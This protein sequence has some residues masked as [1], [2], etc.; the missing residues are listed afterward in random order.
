MIVVTNGLAMSLNETAI[1]FNEHCMQLIRKRNHL[2]CQEAESSALTQPQ[3]SQFV[4][5]WKRFALGCAIFGLACSA[6]A[7]QKNS[8][9]E[10]EKRGGGSYQRHLALMERVAENAGPIDLLFV[11]DSITQAW[12]NSGKNV[13]QRYYASNGRKSVNI[14]ISGDRT[15]HVLWRLNEGAVE[16]LEPKVAVVMIGTN[17]SGSDRNSAS[18]MVEGVR[19]VVTRLH[20]LLPETKILLL[21]IFPRGEE[22]NEIRGKILQ[23]NQAVQKMED[24]MEGTVFFLDIGHRF[25]QSDGRISTDIMPDFLHLTEAGYEI[26]AQSIEPTLASLLSGSDASSVEAKSTSAPFVAEAPEKDPFD[27]AGDWRWLIRGP[28]NQLVEFLMHLETSTEDSSVTGYFLMSNDQGER[29]LE[30]L[31]GSRDGRAI[32]MTAQ[33]KRENGEVMK[34]TMEGELNEVNDA[35]EGVAKAMFNG[36]EVVIPWNASRKD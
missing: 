34:Y 4:S 25:L 23:V 14:G 30:I 26:W 35:M 18:E 16:G 11:G 20:E 1:S 29:R 27:P 8:A 3:S 6:W 22:F 17:N 33:R 7:Q 32:K 28:E 24:E 9:V 12:E 10:P 2:N 13:W 21:G 19:V 36:A 5:R 15:Q 31:D